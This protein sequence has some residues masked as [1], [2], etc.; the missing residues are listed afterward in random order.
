MKKSICILI[1]LLLCWLIF[2]SAESENAED[3]IRKLDRTLGRWGIAMT[4]ELMGNACDKLSSN[5][6]VLVTH[7]SLRANHPSAMSLM[8]QKP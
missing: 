8:P 2:L 4:A 7:F 1:C 6:P 5:A 3:E